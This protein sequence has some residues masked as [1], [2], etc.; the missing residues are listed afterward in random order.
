MDALPQVIAA[1]EEGLARAATAILDGAVVAGP[2][3]TLYG[4]L[5][6]A[7]EEQAVEAV[8]AI[9]GRPRGQPIP[10]LVRDLGMAGELVTDI[11]S[12]AVGLAERHWPGALTLVL[13]A[14]ADLNPWLLGPGG[15]VG[16]RVSSD[17]VVAGL[18]E[19]VQSPLTA[20]SAN[21]SGAAAATTAGQARLAGVALVLDDGVRDAPA[22]T[23]VSFVG[24]QQRLLRQ[25][26][27]QV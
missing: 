12:A 10:V 5:A 22:S 21:L 13:Q 18:I 4:L 25:G 23:V 17:P 24:G 6:L 16:V 27:I 2:T 14:R 26:A 9:K 11:P 15:G 3:E 1:D 8:A 7:T 19:R 20:T